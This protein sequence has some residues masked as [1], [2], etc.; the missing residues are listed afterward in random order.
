MVANACKSSVSKMSL[1]A[2]AIMVFNVEKFNY[3]NRI[4]QS[5]LHLRDRTAL[6]SAN[7]HRNL[8]SREI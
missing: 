5:K 8:D 3:S 2:D 7:E 4:A 6:S 1:S